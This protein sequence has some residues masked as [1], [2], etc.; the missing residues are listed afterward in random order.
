M[1][2]VGSVE[3]GSAAEVREE[4]ADSAAEVREEVADSVG[5]VREAEA[6]SEGADLEVVVGLVVEVK[7]VVEDWGGEV[8]VVAVA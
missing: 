4:V 6:D 7:V 2:A 3:E 8:K 5:E 1:V